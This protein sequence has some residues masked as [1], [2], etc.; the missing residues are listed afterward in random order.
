M[1]LLWIGFLGASICAHE[2][3][4][5][6]ME[7]FDR[8]LPAR[9]ARYVHAAGFL[10][11][12]GFCA[13]MGLL[14]YRYVFDPEVGMRAIGG[15][16]AQMR[17]PDW[18]STVAVPIAFAMTTIRFVGA[19]VSTLLGGSYGKSATEES[20]LAAAE[21]AAKREGREDPAKEAS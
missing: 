19:G 16:S 2:G 7:A 1:L 18:L 13:F 4:H 14:G 5:L 12:A 10:F 11:T 20:L 9:A 21:Q 15:V 17:I 6:T 8:M 3:K